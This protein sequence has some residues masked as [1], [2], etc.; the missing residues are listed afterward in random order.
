MNFSDMNQSFITEFSQKLMNHYVCQLI[1]ACFVR[2]ILL[3]I[4]PSEFH[5]FIYGMLFF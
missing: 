4:R 1:K 2:N 5:T 3:H